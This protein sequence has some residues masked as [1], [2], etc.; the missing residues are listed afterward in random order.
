MQKIAS[1]F[2]ILLSSYIAFNQ[3]PTV[4]FNANPLSACVGEVINF[5]STSVAGTSPIINYTWDFGDGTTQNTGNTTISHTYT[6]SGTFSIALIATDQNG[7]SVPHAKQ[8]Y[9]TINPKP[10]VNFT[11]ATNGCTLPVGVTYSN[12][13]SSGASFSYAWTFNG[14]NPSSSNAQ[15]PPLINYASSNTFSTQLIVTNTATGCQSTLSQNINISNFTAEFSYNDTI[16]VGTTTTFTDLTTTGANQWTWNNGSGNTSTNQNPTFT[17]NTPG[18]YTVSLTAQNSNNG[19]TD[20]V[21]HTIVVLPLPTVSFTA[22]PTSGCTPL[23]VVFTNTSQ[24]GLSNYIWNFGDN[25]ANSNSP[26]PTVNHTYTGSGFF[27]VSLTATGLGGC[28]KTTTMNNFIQTL[29]PTAQFSATPTSGCSP[30]TVNFSDLSSSSNPASD[31]IVSWLWNYGN[32]NTSTGQT[33]QQQIYTTGVYSVSLTITTQNGCTDTEIKTGYIQVGEIDLVDFSYAP[34]IQ[35]AKSNVTFTNQSI[36]S[37]PHTS[38]EVT[39]NWD[40]GDD[41]TSTQENPTW[42]YPTDTGYFDV[43]F[44]IT[45][46]GCKDT[47]KI[48]SAVFIN[49]PI[50]KFTPAQTLYCNPSS[51]PV[52]VEVT[53]EAIIG[54]SSDDVKMIW[55]WGD[56]GN[57][58]TTLEDADLDPDDDGSSS[59]N[60]NAYGS[61]T[62]KQVVY[63]YTT[64]CSDS[65]TKSIVISQTQASFTL[66]NDSICKNGNVVLTSTSTSS[67]TP[68]FGTLSY[69]MGNGVTINGASPYTY[70]TAGS[71]DIRLI[72][73]NTEGCADT[74]YFL[75]MDVL[76]LPTAA[77]TPSANVGCAPIS[78]VY[79]NN[80]VPTGNGYPTLS[81]FLWTFPNGS[82]QTTNSLN[83]NTSYLFNTQGSFNTTLIVTDGFGCVSSP[84]TA[85]MLIT[86]PE[87]DFEIE[88]VIC[89][90]TNPLNNQLNSDNQSTGA[91][92]LSYE[93]FIDNSYYDNT[94]NITASFNH[95]YSQN[96][97]NYVHKITVY[98]TDENGCVD[99][100]SKNVVVSLPHANFNLD[101]LKS[102]NLNITNTA[103]CP[104]VIGYY[105]NESTSYGTFTSNWDFYNGVHSVFTNP[106]TTF[107]FAGQYSLRL[108]IT[109]QY[110]CIDDTILPDYLVIGGP[111]VIPLITPGFDPCDNAFIFDTLS[112]NNISNLSWDFGNGQSTTNLPDS[113]SYPEAGTYYPVLTVTDASGC[114]VPY[115]DTLI[116]S[117]DIVTAN[118]T[119]T[120]STAEMGTP[121]T[122]TDNST[123]SNPLTHWDWYFGDFGSPNQFNTTN[124]SVNYTYKLPYL[125]NSYLVVTD[126]NG[127]KDTAN[128]IIH[129]TGTV[130]IPNVFTPNGDN[131]NNLLAFEQDIFEYFDVLI[132][133]RWGDPIINNKNLHG[134]TIWD[135]KDDKGNVVVDGVYFYQIKGAFI[136]KTPFDKSGYVTIFS[137]SK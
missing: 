105:S 108:E 128:I 30:L 109:D 95:D 88:D 127:C 107:Y 27:N 90:S 57:N 123:S 85:N 84:S 42:N 32:G 6:S 62:I 37:V 12:S 7:N 68:A 113:I 17:Y 28:S 10:I 134:T 81:S 135:G 132:L 116:V 119:V 64:G 133:N 86:L 25:T 104:P 125:Y 72:A 41:G 98:V 55:R 1:L 56:S 22:T 97:T 46:R 126:M 58:S 60:Y 124:A 19:C 94:E 34:N 54:K 131:V 3:G 114:S 61:Y 48:D 33:P 111:S 36:I 115:K 96:I 66:S 49:P 16:C 99:S 18:T 59:F 100:L 8:N 39:Y 93:W 14:G 137:T 71:Y 13:S 4:N 80:S 20:N 82:T 23:N 21:T 112:G 40:F 50:S 43:E 120:P 73:T 45:F 91:G 106:S 29:P 35:C 52:N 77:I 76:E 53:D 69:N 110:G 75:G 65:T 89:V 136:D 38:N 51:F 103:S 11:M 47:L 121:I 74:A 26:G 63:N 102:Y 78:V 9:I 67:S 117:A 118:Y 129:I 24:N 2:A 101:S 83:T 31:P 122:F 87:P 79:Q 70:N 92:N 44:I 130:N 15:I 5:T